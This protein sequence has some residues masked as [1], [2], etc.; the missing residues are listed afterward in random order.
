MVIFLFS[1][2]SQVLLLLFI[3]AGLYA[4]NILSPNHNLISWTE[5]MYVLSYWC[6]LYIVAPIRV[7]HRL[8]MLITCPPPLMHT[9][10]T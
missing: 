5:W 1:S 6:V 7:G 3:M 9:M 10:R 4:P 8:H 2:D